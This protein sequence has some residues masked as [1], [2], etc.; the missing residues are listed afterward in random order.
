MSSSYKKRPKSI[1]T[2]RLL[3]KDLFSNHFYELDKALNS[4]ANL[5]SNLKMYVPSIIKKQF[6]MP[7]QQLRKRIHSS[8]IKKMEKSKLFFLNESV[9]S[10]F[11]KMDDNLDKSMQIYQN[12]KIENNLFMNKFKNLQ[13]IREKISRKKNSSAIIGPANFSIL[14]E[15]V[16]S[17]K[18]KHI[19]I[20]NEMFKNKDLYR[21]TP[22]VLKNKQDIDFFYLFN[23]DKYYKKTNMINESYSA[24]N[25]NE[26]INF[27]RNNYKR[28]IKFDKLK[29]T[30][31][32]KK[33]ILNYDKRLK[34]LNNESIDNNEDKNK[35]NDNDNM[36]QQNNIDYEEQVQKDR[37]EINRL[38]NNIKLLD[39]EIYSIDENK[40]SKNNNFKKIN[41]DA[42]LSLDSLSN[43]QSINR[44]DM[45][46][47]NSFS[48][49]NKINSAACNKNLKNGKNI[50][51]L[52]N[53]NKN[54][55]KIFN[56]KN[57]SSTNINK[58]KNNIFKI[59]MKNLKKN[60]LKRNISP[61]TKTTFYSANS[62]M[63]KRNSILK[64]NSNLEYKKIFRDKN[65]HKIDKLFENIKDTEIAYEVIKRMTFANKAKA[66]KK[67]EEYFNSKK[68]N[69]DK[70][71]NN[72]KQKEIYNFFDTIKKV[73]NQYNC[74][75]EIQSLHLSIH[76]SMSEKMKMDLDEI[77]NLDKIIQGV[78]YM[79]Y[80]SL[81]KGQS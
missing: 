74:K 77:S 61:N 32:F 24:K 71:K 41:N 55:N 19:L 56:N 2:N 34:E 14:N 44:T 51:F 30:R 13:K 60:I 81:L 67:I 40:S 76:K 63:P 62:S 7:I 26:I 8:Q 64:N 59:S 78:E 6:S 21:A 53:L 23:H 70:I 52:K 68:Y 58:I 35:N 69:V 27:N 54:K 65:H 1:S 73:I 38:I 10:I 57:S 9:L 22:I 49:N 46:K 47:K 15:L 48:L 28:N 79:Y 31:L 42:S 75:Q 66:L 45:H 4:T 25:R 5:N 36:A 80:L 12:K 20:K 37:E 3:E 33:L 11:H 43:I 16:K 72:I 18:K 50:F 29:E 17:Y 39:K